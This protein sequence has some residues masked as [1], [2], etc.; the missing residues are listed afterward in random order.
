MK[1]GFTLVELMAVVVIIIVIGLIVFP[2]VSDTLKR[3]KE[4][5][6]NTQ[7]KIITEAATKWGI[8]NP[9]RLPDFYSGDK[10]SVTLQEL[11]KNG[12]IEIKD[13]SG[14]LYNPLTNEEMNGCV[15]VSYSEE[16]NQYLYD[17]VEPC[18]ESPTIAISNKTGVFN[19]KG[20]A[21]SPFYVTITG[22]GSN[23]S[24][25]VSNEECNPT[26]IVNSS[27]GEVYINQNGNY[28]VC[29]KAINTVG[30]SEIVCEQ[31]KLDTNAPT[32]ASTTVYF[33]KGDNKLTDLITA[34]SASGYNISCDKNYI[35]ELEI[36]NNTVNCTVTSESGLTTTKSI[37]FT[38]NTLKTAGYASATFI[39]S[40]TLKEKVESIKLLDYID[41]PDNA[42][43]VVDVSEQQN[44]SIMAWYTDN[45]SDGMYELYIGQNGGVIANINSSCLFQ[46][47]N[48]V[49][50]LDVS[51]LDT[52]KVANMSYMF[53]EMKKLSELNI[54]DFNTSKVT[55]MDSMFAGGNSLKNL[56]LSS[57]D[58]SS[59]LDMAYMFSSCSN[60]ETLNISNFNTSNVVTMFMMFYNVFNLKELDVSNF[61]TS[62]V[63]NMGGM[64]WMAHRVSE[65]TFL[66]VSNFDTSKV[67]NM[68][69]M[70]WN[71]SNI[72]ELDVSKF[73]T[74][75][76]SQMNYMF[77]GLKN[78]TE[79]DVSN[80]DTSKV[81]NMN[82]MFRGCSKITNLDLSDF[83][84][85]N[86]TNMNG[87]FSG[88]GSITHLDLKSFNTT[89]VTNIGSMF[90]ETFKIT[91]L[92]I[93]HFDTSKVTDMSFLFYNTR[94]KEIDLSHFD[95]SKVTD[96]SYM[97]EFAGS[98]TSLD[99]SHFNTSNVTNMS[100][101]FYGMGGLTEL[102]ISNF[103]T[104]N[105]TVFSRMFDAIKDNPTITINENIKT[106][107]ESRL[108][109]AGKT[110][111]FVTAG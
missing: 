13:E 46:K 35:S 26:S 55:N 76:V 15:L 53:Y 34:T 3:G 58:T 56:D 57:F 38:P 69:F 79:L 102:N 66:D 61:D 12:Y 22:S 94:L 108:T 43:E 18:Q 51:N 39:G 63:T 74:S 44:K 100:F 75:N 37:V 68:S 52:S 84:T 27:S 60:L 72:T 30:N 41:I 101:M 82:S 109:E 42:K 6:Y 77:S 59:V 104:S 20:W 33:D 111:T 49:I 45:D 67:T 25:C 32:L 2:I 17:Y 4:N 87:M 88:M 90:S 89:N 93:S 106:F 107:I 99:L 95:T 86:V 50:N 36:G 28:H 48:N 24:Y 64:F 103:D 98:L 80:F 7:V 73:N 10:V 1:K 19:D 16:Y 91:E 14:K 85:T 105:V 21:T 31:Y 92:D 11:I 29:A 70:F 8:S 81:T 110:A 47:F 78:V 65:I 9:N 83:D 23:Y 62:N 97:F 40:K 71:L 96:M 54:T 5:A